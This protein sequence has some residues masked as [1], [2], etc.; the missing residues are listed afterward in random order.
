MSRYSR[1]ASW[2]RRV[3]PLPHSWNVTSDSIAAW[4][5]GAVGAKDLLL[6]KPPHATGA[7]LVDP[8]FAQT[9]D[10]LRTEVIPAHDIETLRMVTRR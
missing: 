5:A 3:D 1:P 2:L 10:G 9:S 7:D 8:Y 6:I 4:V